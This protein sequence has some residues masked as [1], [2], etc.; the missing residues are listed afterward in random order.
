MGD[1][2]AEN[3]LAAIE[4]SK[5]TTL[6]RFIFGLGIIHVGATV[7]E[8]L[9]SHFRDIRALMDASREELE[10]VAGIG[11]EIA[12]QVHDFFAAEQNREVVERLLG[13]G[14]SPRSASVSLADVPQTLSG[15]AFVL[16]GTLEGYT[17]ESAAEAIKQRG[18]KVT[19]SVS[20]KTDYVVA[21]A[22]PGSKLTKAQELGV[23]VLE[24][25]GFVGLLEV[26]E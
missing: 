19:S 25:E 15:K 3:L 7:A 2:S 16:T 4:K 5:D 21:G 9:A 13:A 12:G 26:G 22:D 11:P 23:M 24:E 20:K 6:A 18:G 10:S 17:R 1:K 14:V 8:L